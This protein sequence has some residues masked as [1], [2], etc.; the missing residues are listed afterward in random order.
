MSIGQ[1]LLLFISGKLVCKGHPSSGK[2][3]PL[4]SSE[5]HYAYSEL[6]NSQP[7]IKDIYTPDTHWRNLCRKYVVQVDLHK[8]LAHL[9]CFQCVASVL[10]YK[11]LAPNGMLLYLLQVC[12]Y[13]N[14]FVEDVSGLGVTN[15]RDSF[16][17]VTL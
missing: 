1:L 7:Q 15:C 13:K 9:T 3:C 11:F 12:R 16:M 17:P 5:W 6:T 8:K 10:L 14:N 4:T 2:D